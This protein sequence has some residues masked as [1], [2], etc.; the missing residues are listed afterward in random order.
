MKARPFAHE[1]LKVGEGVEDL[2]VAACDE[3]NSAENFQRCN[4]RFYIVAGERASDDVNRCGVLKDVRSASLEIEIE[5]KEN[6][7]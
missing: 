2:L 4:F 5:E 7:C 1:L 6:V 3:T